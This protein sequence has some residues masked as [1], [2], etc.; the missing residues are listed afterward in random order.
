MICVAHPAKQAHSGELNWPSRIAY[1]L[2]IYD[3]H[4]K[5]F[6]EVLKLNLSGTRP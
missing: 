6:P 1:S 3:L 2:C 4:F 5:S